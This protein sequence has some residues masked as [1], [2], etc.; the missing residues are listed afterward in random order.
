MCGINAFLNSLSGAE[1]DSSLLWLSSQEL[2]GTE[3]TSQCPRKGNKIKRKPLGQ[4]HIDINH[5]LL[6]T[7]R[8]GLLSLQRVTSTW[9]SDTKESSGTS[10][11]WINCR[12]V[13]LSTR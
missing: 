2:S 10:Y 11:W 5:Y 12:Q 13:P 1:K 6:G 8:N 9:S 3:V 4:I 7:K